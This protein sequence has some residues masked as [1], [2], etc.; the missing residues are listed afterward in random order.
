MSREKPLEAGDEDD[1]SLIECF[2][3]A[4]RSDLADLRPRVHRVG[5]DPR[6][7]AGEG[8]GLVAEVVYRHRHECT[9]DAVAGREQQVEL[10]RVWLQRDAAG[11]LE[12]RIRRVAHCRDG[13]HHA[14]ALL[15][16]FDD[17]RNA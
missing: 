2:D 5:D 17:A 10:A 7:R 8:D 9:R 13:R 12:Q 14:D 6:L 3:H 16:R 11:E 15:A 1:P 4:H